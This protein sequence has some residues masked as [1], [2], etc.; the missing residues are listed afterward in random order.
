[1]RDISDSY[2]DRYRRRLADLD[3]IEQETRSVR[4]K[5]DRELMEIGERRMRV[6]NEI[7]EMRRIITTMIDTGCD[8]VEAKL[9][10][11]G[12]KQSIWEMNSMPDISWDS[13]I[14]VSGDGGYSIDLSSIT[15][16]TVQAIAGD[17]YDDGNGMI[18]GGYVYR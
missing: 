9:K 1:M 17:G 4:E 14:S 3:A 10:N 7:A 11:D 16:I 6:S 15:D 2:I 18:S 5:Y 8:P 13:K 12:M